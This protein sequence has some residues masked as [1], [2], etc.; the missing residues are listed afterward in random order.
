MTSP[1]LEMRR[2]A[3]Y[4]LYWLEDTTPAGWFDATGLRRLA[5][6]ALSI[7]VYEDD[8]YCGSAGLFRLWHGV[9]EAWLVLLSHPTDSWGFMRE[10]QHMIQVGE[11]LTKA[12]RL[13]AYC[14]A[15]YTPGLA[16]A[17]RMGFIHEATLRRATPTQ[18]DLIL[19]S[20]VRP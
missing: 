4:D 9:Y 20:K 13:Q 5:D 8:R 10:L 11:R 2:Y 14:L 16:L 12:H 1:T 3:P 15:E 19:L 7:S 6:P 18:T 17:K